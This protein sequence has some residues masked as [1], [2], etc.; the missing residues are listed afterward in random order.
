[1]SNYEYNPK[2]HIHNKL[3]I[4]ADNFF[5]WSKNHIYKTNYHTM[6]S[7]VK[8]IKRIQ[9]LQKIKLYQVI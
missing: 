7:H 5:E 2:Q 1:M 9:Y 3:N 6:R 8:K 4:N